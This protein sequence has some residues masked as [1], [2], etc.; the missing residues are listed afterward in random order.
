MGPVRS[1][2]GSNTSRNRDRSRLVGMT[3][4]SGT[5]A[6]LRVL[7]YR[8]VGAWALALGLSFVIGYK[9]RE[10]DPQFAEWLASLEEGDGLPEPGT[11]LPFDATAYCKGTTTASGVV[12]PLQ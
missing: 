1:V 9:A 11:R 7:S 10:L 12:V 4:S 6:P 5:V 8:R 3:D 2:E